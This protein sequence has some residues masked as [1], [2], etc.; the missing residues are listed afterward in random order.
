MSSELVTGIGSPAGETELLGLLLRRPRRTAWRPPRPDLMP[1]PTSTVIFSRFGP[2][3]G[4]TNSSAGDGLPSSRYFCMSVTRAGTSVGSSQAD[5]YGPVDRVHRVLDLAA[6]RRVDEGH[7][8][9]GRLELGALGRLRDVDGVRQPD[10]HRVS[11]ASW[12]GRAKKPTS[13]T[14]SL[15]FWLIAEIALVSIG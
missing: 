3:I 5:T 12:A 1:E 10:G 13:S 2:L 15:K 9:L 4:E 8:L 11:A 6:L 7:E 14:L